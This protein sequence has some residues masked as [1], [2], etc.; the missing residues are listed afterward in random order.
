MSRLGQGLRRA[1]QSVGGVARTGAVAM[2]L[3]SGLSAHAPLA[4]AASPVSIAVL[5]DSLTAGFGLPQAEAFPARL[6]AALQ[7]KGRN[8]KVINA[9]VSG[10]TSAGGLSRLDWT[11]GDKPDM[12]IV[13]LGANDALRGIDPKSTEANLDAIL[14]KLKASGVR[15]LLTGMLAPPNYGR[16]YDEAFKAIFP[17]LAGKHGVPLYPF[18]LDGVAAEADLNQ[19]DGMHP[20]ARGVDVVVAHILPDVEKVLDAH[21]SGS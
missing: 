17:R 6:E 15:I 2:A 3:L 16:D 18:F 14:A 21:G 1:G 8:V 7:A 19:A 11:L 10:D 20:N 13:E 5:G 12:V 9:G 4:R